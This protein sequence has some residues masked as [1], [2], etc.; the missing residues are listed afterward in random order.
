[1]QKVRKN[2][3][4]RFVFVKKATLCAHAETTGRDFYA[5]AKKLLDKLF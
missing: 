4:N 1:V 3:L 5:G 2:T